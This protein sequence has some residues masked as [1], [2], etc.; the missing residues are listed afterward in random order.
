MAIGVAFGLMSAFFLVGS[1]SPGVGV[2][3]PNHALLLWQ[4]SLW[5]IMASKAFDV[6]TVF[7]L[8][9]VPLFLLMGELMNRSGMGERCTPLF[10]WIWFLPGGLI[11]TNIVSSAI[12]AACSGSSVAT[13]ATISRA[14][15]PSFR[16]RG[17][18]E[19]MVIGSLAQAAPS[20]SSPSI[21]LIL[22]GVLVE[23][24]VG[25]LYMPDSSRSTAFSL[26][27]GDDRRTS[28]Y[29][30]E[31]WPRRSRRQFLPLGSGG[32]KAP[33][34]YPTFACT[35]PSSPWCSVSST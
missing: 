21:S 22:Y 5:N 3:S 13:S 32:N 27:H 20:A 12:F 4:A 10:R 17:Y 29:Y 28:P 14:S 9:A 2:V 31:A 1:M 33:G 15:L 35:W 24:S 8:V 30:G 6:N 7:I 23:E 11:H 25:R 26:F 16:Q 34:P 19:R 18:S